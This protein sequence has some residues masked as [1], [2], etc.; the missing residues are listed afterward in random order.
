M[1]KGDIVFCC[2]EVFTEY[3]IE[4][5]VHKGWELLH[6]PNLSGNNF[7]CLYR[8]LNYNPKQVI[9]LGKTCIRTG[10][11]RDGWVGQEDYEPSYLDSD[12]SHAVWVVSPY[13]ENNNR[14]YKPFYILETDVVEQ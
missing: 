14:Y 8:K 12:K 2:A 5:E 3:E 6:R 7:R 13:I 10:V 4:Y 9:V 1:K 11:K